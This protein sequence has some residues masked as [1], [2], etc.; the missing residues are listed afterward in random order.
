MNN[1]I[2]KKKFIYNNINSITNNKNIIDFIINNNIN[3]SQNKNGMHVNISILEDKLI[4]EIYNIIF[5][6]INDKTEDEKYTHEYNEAIKNIKSKNTI[7]SNYH[8]N[9]N[10]LKIKLNDTQREMI[11][12]IL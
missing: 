2:N 12:L 3:Y 1:I 9:T 7:K 8:N 5:Y 11:N 6:D 4:N 10:Y